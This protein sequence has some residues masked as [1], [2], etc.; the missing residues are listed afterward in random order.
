MTVSSCSCTPQCLRVFCHRQKN[1]LTGLAWL[2]AVNCPDKTPWNIASLKVMYT[3]Q[4]PSWCL[5]L[6][7]EEIYRPNVNTIEHHYHCETAVHK[8]LVH[9]AW[10]AS[11]LYPAQITEKHHIWLPGYLKEFLVWIIQINYVKNILKCLSWVLH[12]MCLGCNYFHLSSIFR[13]RV[14]PSPWHPP[15]LPRDPG[16]EDPLRRL[17]AVP[18]RPLVGAGG[19]RG[20]RVLWA[21]QVQR[22]NPQV[23]SEK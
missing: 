16:G 17:R 18:V 19:E 21:G 11:G 22:E 9:N 15:R 20:A 4:V 23:C 6:D 3:G 13:D 7:Q 12:M 14:P 1:R 2:A 5:I 8:L 10:R